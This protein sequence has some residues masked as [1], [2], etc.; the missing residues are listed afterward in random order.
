MNS[1]YWLI[2]LAVLLLIEILTLGLTTIWFSAGALIAFMV[3]LA[4]DSL[5]VQILVFFI[6][7]FTLLIFTRPIAVKFLNKGRTKTNYESYIG[8][9]GKV[10]Q[11]I[12]NVDNTG[13]VVVDGQYWT[14]RSLEPK[15]VIEVNELVTVNNI[16]GVK[17]I[18]SVAKEDM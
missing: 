7:S 9:E 17:L 8:R 14:A 1:I 4:T 2:L 18:V 16:T 6:G 15:T 13:E 5:F 10:T 3:S 11:R 12:S